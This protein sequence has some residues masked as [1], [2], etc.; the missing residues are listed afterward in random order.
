L[1][2]YR[3]MF[4]TLV[5][6]LSDHTHGCA[7]VLGAVTLGAR[8][9][10][11]HFT[12]S[13]GREGPDHKF[14]TNPQDW[15]VM[16]AETRK[17]ERALGSAD[18]DIAQNEKQT[19]VIQRRCMRAARDIKIGEVITR[20][21]IDV[22]RPATPGGITPPEI[23]AVIGKRALASLPAGKELRWVDLGE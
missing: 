21:M 11:R 9:I 18:K 8:V 13:N 2:T 16:V 14:A 12:D 4:P 23:S 20:Q 22:L 6:G 10:E 7:T 5:L 19:A 1:N 15:A 17:L 3:T